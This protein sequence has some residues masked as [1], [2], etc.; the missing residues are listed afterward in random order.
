MRTIALAA[1]L[2]AAPVAAEAQG[3]KRPTDALMMMRLDDPVGFYIAVYGKGKETIRKAE[4]PFPAYRWFSYDAQKVRIVFEQDGKFWRFLR[5]SSTEGYKITP[6]TATAR[7]APIARYDLSLITVEQAERREL[8]IKDREEADK[9]AAEAARTQAKIDA[10]RAAARAVLDA[11]RSVEVGDLRVSASPENPLQ[12]VYWTPGAMIGEA[13]AKGSYLRLK[14]DITNTSATR[15]HTYL[16]LAPKQFGQRPSALLKDELG[17]TYRNI[18]APF[19][20]YFAGQLVDGEAVYPGKT[21]TD[22]LIFEG[23]VSAATAL[24]LTIP[25]GTFGVATDVTLRFAPP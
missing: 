5:F 8:V 9:R 7:L 10:E 14:L 22:Y 2:L 13:L 21:I 15:K 11:Q 23:A 6:E 17:N 18:R 4:H 1:L 3:G 24:T 25:G 20:T 19:G 16:G 12:V